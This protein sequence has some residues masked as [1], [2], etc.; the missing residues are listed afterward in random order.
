MSDS[1]TMVPPATA[2]RGSGMFSCPKCK[3]ISL[4]LAMVVVA[5][6]GVAAYV[7]DGMSF[8]IPAEIRAFTAPDGES[9]AFWSRSECLLNPDQGPQAFVPDC[10][11]GAGQPRILLWGDSYA[12]AM[13]Q[14]FVQLA[15]D[16]QYSVGWL[17]SSACPP[18]IGLVHPDRRFCKDNNDWII[19]RIRQTPP[20]IVILASTWIYSPQIIKDGLAQTVSQ[21]RAAGVK[22]II[23]MGPV[24]TWQGIGMARNFIDFYFHSSHSLMPKYTF[25]RSNH[26][27]DVATEQML[28]EQ[29]ASL[30][31][32]YVS[33]LGVMCNKQGCLARVGDHDQHLATFDAGHLTVSGARAV[34]QEL[35]P[36][37]LE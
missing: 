11:P 18:F 32:R 27:W 4:L 22:K 21:L 3:D 33:P 36:G 24:A 9:P 30:G 5:L 35:L 12:A 28:Q 13:A 7:T 17:S 8:R 19:Q 31:V 23:V 25:F 29:A 15:G 26:A 14:G 16:H 10:M 6:L 20:D 2:R 34:V 37:I 1:S